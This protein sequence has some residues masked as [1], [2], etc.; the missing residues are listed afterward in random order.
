[1]AET[2]NN[3]EWNIKKDDLKFSHQIMFDGALDNINMF[4]LVIKTWRKLNSINPDILILGGYSYSACWAAFLWAKIKRK[5]TIIWSSS[6]ANDK[7]RSFL[8]EKLKGV[9]VSKCDAANVYGQRSRDY[10]VRLGMQKSKIFITGNTTDNHFYYDQTLKLKSNRRV[11]YEKHNVP[12]HNFLY[13]GRFSPEK[14]ILFL[15]KTYQRLKAEK[16]DWGLILIGDG[17]QRSEIENYINKY[18]V[19]DVH[20]P[21]FKQKEDIPLYLALANVLILPSIY[22]SWGLVVNE[23][24]AA[25]LPVLVSK[26]CG[27]Y[28]D[29]I[30]DGINGFHFD[31]FDETQLLKYM[32]KIS[33]EKEFLTKMGQASMDI[34]KEYTPENAAKIII[35]TIEY[36]CNDTKF[37]SENG[38]N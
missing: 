21:G 1:M 3:R 2:E 32:K 5:K 35:K 7:S 34:I 25:G 29:L 19:K 8:K 24:M 6:N 13:I 12:D 22:E 9:L 37:I 38:L 15:L 26:K 27:C 28:P 16:C 4:K 33:H 30:K 10:L 14:N 36:A 17:P 31:P 20:M 11:L 23:A 18:A